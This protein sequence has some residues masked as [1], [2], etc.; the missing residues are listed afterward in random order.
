MSTPFRNDVDA[1]KTRLTSLDDEL[2]TLRARAAEYEALR[3]RL[4]HLEREHADVR[5]EIDARQS[6]RAV[7]LLDSLRVASPCN[8]SWDDMIGDART[9][10]CGKCQKHVH[11]ISELTREEAE[12]FLQAATESVCI[13]MYQRAD[14]TVLTTDCP[15]G[16]R[17]KRVK[18]LFLAT[19]GTGLAAAASAVAFWAFEET[20]VQGAMS[21]IPVSSLPPPHDSNAVTGAVPW[22]SSTSEVT[23]AP[24]FATP[25]D[26]I[27]GGVLP[28]SQPRKPLTPPRTAKPPVPPVR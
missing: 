12:T 8:E 24:T 2:T 7:P 13:R 27:T 19:V 25:P 9:R 11:N 23:P 22:P 1:L 3:E 15:V 6:R 14:G 28:T 21:P 20:V 26:R 16:A 17:K 18:R 5:R 10:F 4:T